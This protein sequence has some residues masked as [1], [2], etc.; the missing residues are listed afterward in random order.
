MAKSIKSIKDL[1]PGFKIIHVMADGTERDSI[2][3]C[4]IP[5][6]PETYPYYKL[7]AELSDRRCSG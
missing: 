7:L 4:I 2:E 1:P 5:L 6:T 3:G